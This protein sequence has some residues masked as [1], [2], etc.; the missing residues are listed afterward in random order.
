M[1]C[2]SLRKVSKNM[3]PLELKKKKSR[4]KVILEDSILL[5]MYTNLQMLF[6]S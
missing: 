5:N 1:N 4:Y 3:W 2:I 6:S